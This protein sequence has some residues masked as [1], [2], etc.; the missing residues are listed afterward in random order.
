MKKKRIYAAIVDLFVVSIIGLGIGFILDD[1]ILPES[2][3]LYISIHYWLLKD[4]YKGMSLG[5][6]IIGIQIIDSK[7]GNIANPIKCVAR[8]FCYFLGIV[9]LIFFLIDS[10]GLRIGD[11]LTLTK[12]VNK[13]PML[14]Q[15]FKSVVYTWALILFI[16]LVEIGIYYAMLARIGPK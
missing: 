1:K 14:K 6:Y 16:F 13:N 4:C 11:Y 7:T 9:E 8:N 10:K 12:V 2:I 3:I 15:N 5:K